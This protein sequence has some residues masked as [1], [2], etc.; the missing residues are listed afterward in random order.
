[1]I[2]LHVTIYDAGQGDQ[3][4]VLAGDDSEELV[5]VTD[6]YEVAAIETEDGRSGFAVVKLEE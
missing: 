1:M 6:Q 3:F 5:E 2:S 4:K